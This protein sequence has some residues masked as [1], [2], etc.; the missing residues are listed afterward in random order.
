MIS[1][2]EI[3]NNINTEWKIPLESQNKSRYG[4][5]KYIV[6]VCQKMNLPQSTASLAMLITNYFFI[7]NCYFNYDKLS[8]ACSALLLSCKAK[9]SQS[10]LKEICDEYNLIKSKTSVMETPHKIKQHIGKYELYL[11]KSLDY[12]IPDDFPYDFINVYSEILYPNNDQE[13][14]NLATKI[15][16]D[17]FFTLA[18]NVYKNYIVALA[19]VVIAA[20]F[21]DI[22]NILDENFKYLDNM[23]KVNKRKMT[24][25]EFNKELYQY[26]NNAWTNKEEKNDEMQI[27]KD[28]EDEYFDKLSL[29]EKLYPNMKMEDLLGC[30]KLIIVFYEDMS[31]EENKDVKAKN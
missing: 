19:C 23:K 20:K 27:D 12:N 26:D 30:I 18:N 15:A 31:K 17:S 24:E 2:E 10:R 5:C 25:E 4:L 14:S 7:K 1:M 29:C 16:N 11:L 3:R 22:P 6:E 21:L 8:L 28:G 9:S 13:I